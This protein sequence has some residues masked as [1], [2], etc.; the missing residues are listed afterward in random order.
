MIKGVYA[1][2]ILAALWWTGSDDAGWDQIVTYLAVACVV[3]VIFIGFWIWNFIRLPAQDLARKDLKIDELENR[4]SDVAKLEVS[5]RDEEPFRRTEGVNSNKKYWYFDLINTGPAVAENVGVRLLSILPTPQIQNGALDYPFTPIRMKSA[6]PF[7]SKINV[8]ENV[9]F[10]IFEVLGPSADEKTW[11]HVRR[12]GSNN[13]SDASLHLHDGE[14]WEMKYRV[15]AANA[16]EVKFTLL[17]RADK[18]DIKI[19][20]QPT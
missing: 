1:A 14:R 5:F 11:W 3:P 13:I 2:A 10:Q 17:V 6:D 4:L 12:F 15:Q 16:V 8:N 9:L 7:D 18:N 20:L 19:E